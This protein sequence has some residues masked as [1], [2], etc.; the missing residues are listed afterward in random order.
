[1]HASF[2][3]LSLSESDWALLRFCYEA[4]TEK[5]RN[6]LKFLRLLLSLCITATAGCPL[7]YLS[8]RSGYRDNMDYIDSSSCVDKTGSSAPVWSILSSPA[9]AGYFV[10]ELPV[11]LKISQSILTPSWLLCGLSRMFWLLTLLF[12]ASTVISCS[13]A[14]FV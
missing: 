1:M 9:V 2:S 4:C 6:G 3:F 8:N 5:S 10:L 14:T 11:P 12:M 13:A 7:S